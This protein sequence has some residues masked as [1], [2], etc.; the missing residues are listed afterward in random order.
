MCRT[1]YF[2]I[3]ERCIVIESICIRPPVLAVSVRVRK[4]IYTRR[5]VGSHYALPFQQ[6]ETDMF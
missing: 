3:S 4:L 6:R 5:T 1:S 2:N